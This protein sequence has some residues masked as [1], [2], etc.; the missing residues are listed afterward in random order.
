MFTKILLPVL[1]SSSLSAF[2]DVVPPVV[3]EATVVPTAQQLYCTENEQLTAE[4]KDFLLQNNAAFSNRQDYPFFI[5]DTVGYWDNLVT[6]FNLDEQNN[7]YMIREA[8]AQDTTD[9]GIKVYYEGLLQ[10]LLKQ[11]YTPEAAKAEA[12]YVTIQPFVQ[13]DIGQT[14]FGYL[15]ARANSLCKVAEELIAANVNDCVNHTSTASSVAFCAKIKTSLDGYRQ[16]IAAQQALF[17]KWEDD[18]ESQPTE[19]GAK[20]VM[21]LIS[22]AM[23]RAARVVMVDIDT[24]VVSGKAEKEKVREQVREEAS[25]QAAAE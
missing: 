4:T 25:A 15:S 21:A 2:A 5:Q 7:I 6:T 14:K 19:E 20:Q 22:Q 8:I 23:D 1:L 3:V 13:Q 24:Y 9:D 11:G 17:Q 18:P 10:D 16:V 12:E